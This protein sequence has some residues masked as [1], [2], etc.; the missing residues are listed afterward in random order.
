M[1]L[2]QQSLIQNSHQKVEE[3]N[4]AQFGNLEEVGQTS[5]IASNCLSLHCLSVKRKFLGS[6]CAKVMSTQKETKPGCFC[7]K[8]CM[9]SEMMY[10]Q[11]YTFT[12]TGGGWLYKA[13][14]CCTGLYWA[15]LGCTG[16]CKAVL[17]CSGLHQV[18][19]G[20]TW[21]Y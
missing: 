9:D 14:L 13:V 7:S 17:G 6:S 18:V 15:V 16:L 19:L 21:L 20:C 2:L 10:T 8:D 11:W 5:K 3:F 4:R 12:C 1:S